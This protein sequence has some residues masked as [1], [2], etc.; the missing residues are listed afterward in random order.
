MLKP[1]MKPITYY[2][3]NDHDE[4]VNFETALLRGISANYG[5]YMVPRGEVPVLSSGTISDMKQ[6]SYAE[7]AFEVLNPYLAVEMPPES[8]RAILDNA[9][10]EKKI[11]TEV[12]HV[13][14]KTYIM[15]LTQGPTYSFKDYAARFFGRML[16]HFLGQ[17][18]L[19][20]VVVVATSGDTGGAVADALLGLDSI[21]NIVF[22]PRGSISEGQRR[23]M[24]TLGGNVYAFEVNGDFDVC[25]ALA[26]DILNDRKLAMQVFGD[27]ERFTSANSISLGRLLPQAVYPFYAYSR[28]SEQGE[29]FI[30]SVPSGNFGDMMGTVIAKQMGLPVTKILCGVNE[31]TEFPDFLESGHYIVR[32]SRKSPSSAMIVSHPSNLARLID[33][34]GGHMYDARDPATRQ[35]VEPGI[36]DRVPDMYEMRR[37]LYSIGVTNAQHYETMKGVYDKYG[38]VLDPHG[39]VGWRT[40]ET[41]LGG[42]HDYPSVIYETADPGKFPDDVMEAI[43]ILPEQPPGMKKQAALKE[44]I[45][46]VEAMPGMTSQGMS[47]SDGQI[48]EGKQKIVEIFR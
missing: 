48:A 14:G 23:Q 15:W 5:L 28:L 25:Q 11:P 12:Q 2:S 45:Y 41:F 33:F 10:S 42:R 3:T 34:Y 6:M 1:A 44:R 21:D 43:G 36:I 27:P 30:A 37:D 26:K 24:T 47:L 40:L 19:K 7:I 13:T 35:V 9:Y 8:L 31:N 18:G 29:G 17:R 22:F 46:S 38:V 20:R 16:N 4:R 32:P 39:A